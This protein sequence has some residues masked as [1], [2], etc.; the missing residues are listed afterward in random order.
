MEITQQADYAIRAVL[1][2][3]LHS[4]DERIFSS[5]IA[6]R[7]GIPAPFLTKIL[8][9]LAAAGIVATQRGV[10]GGIRLTRPAEQVTLLQVVEAIDGPI[11]LNRCVRNPRECARNTTCI[12]HPVW[13]KICADL[14]AQ[15][16]S[17]HFARLAD[18]ARVSASGSAVFCP[19]D[20]QPLEAFPADRV[21]TAHADI[22]EAPSGG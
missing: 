20:L 21:G 18:D 4:Q 9:R 3:A 14:R 16:H 22:S 10:N 1:E 19:I 13:L 8:A 6:R 7:Q 15:L 5:E 2:L 17:C 11:T 12:V